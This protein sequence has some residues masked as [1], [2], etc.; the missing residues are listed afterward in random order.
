LQSI[1]ASEELCKQAT[2]TTGAWA[3]SLVSTNDDDIHASVLEERWAK[4]KAILT[5]LE[6]IMLEHE[7]SKVLTQAATE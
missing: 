5:N 1:G 4:T 2:E 7:A 6:E 3:G